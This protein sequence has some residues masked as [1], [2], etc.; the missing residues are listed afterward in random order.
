M[1]IRMI[2]EGRDRV[3]GRAKVTGAASFDAYEILVLPDGTAFGS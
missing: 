2:G 1:T 3:D